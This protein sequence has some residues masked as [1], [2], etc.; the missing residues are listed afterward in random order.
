MYR[1]RILAVFWF[2]I[3]QKRA[4]SKEESGHGSVCT[5][6]RREISIFLAPYKYEIYWICK[7]KKGCINIFVR[8][9]SVYVFIIKSA[10]KH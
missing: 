6:Y 1:K 3:W 2:I 9:G 7:N 5:V 4:Q 10:M 8:V